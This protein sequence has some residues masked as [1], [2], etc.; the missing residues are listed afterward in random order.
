MIYGYLNILY[1]NT[2]VIADT[3]MCLHTYPVAGGGGWLQNVFK[4][5]K[6][7]SPKITLFRV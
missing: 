6:I 7:N 2:L 1:T 5:H 4:G 3:Y